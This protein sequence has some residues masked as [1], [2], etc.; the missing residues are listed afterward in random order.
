MKK[1]TIKK[2]TVV[3]DF[4]GVI[5]S[6]TSGWHQDKDETYIPDP[7]TPGIGFAIFDLKKDYEIVIVS[8]RCRSQK[9]RDAIMTWCCQNGI[10]F[11][12]VLAEK[13]PA[14]CYHQTNKQ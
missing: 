11:D 14:V 9:G 7:P 8:S 5:H 10:Y 4:D 6:Y 1:E 3:F 12:R 2:P 13:P